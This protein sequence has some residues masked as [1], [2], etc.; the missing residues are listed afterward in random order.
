M[1]P[2]SVYYLH[3]NDTREVEP[4][5]MACQDYVCCVMADSQQHAIEITK[6][7]ALN[8]K[9]AKHIK[10]LGIGHC[11][12]EWTDY[13]QPMRTDEMQMRQQLDAMFERIYAKN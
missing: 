9:K 10:I 1:Q 2:H 11:K 12:E 4:N 3:F 7:I 5:W 8:Q 13:E 6:H